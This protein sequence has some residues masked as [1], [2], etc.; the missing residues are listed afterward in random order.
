[1]NKADLVLS[2]SGGLQEESP[3]FN[4]PILVLRDSTERPEIIDAG[5][6]LLVGTNEDKVYNVT[7]EI[8]ENKKKY[9]EMSGIKNPFGDGNTSMRIIN[10]IKSINEK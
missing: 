3:S 7:R 10:K 5:G 4:K 8:L 6:G 1:M 2:D 9:K